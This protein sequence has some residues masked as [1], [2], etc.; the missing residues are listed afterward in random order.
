MNT[1]QLSTTN[2][3][4]TNKRRRLQKLATLG[5]RAAALLAL[6]TP[7]AA[8]GSY[9]Y[10]CNSLDD[11]IS[12]I[13]PDTGSTVQTLAAGALP[14]GIDSSSVGKEVLIAN[15]NDRTLTEIDN[16]TLTLQP[17]TSIGSQCDPTGLGCNFGEVLISPDGQRAYIS[18]TDLIYD[19]NI[20]G[21]TIMLAMDL[22]TRTL[23]RVT[24][25]I[26]HPHPTQEGTGQM[27]LTQDGSKLYTT[28]PKADKLF[29]IDTQTLQ[30]TGSIPVGDEPND[31]A[32]TP[33][34]TRMYVANTLSNDVSV[35]D[36]STD[37]VTAT[38][39]GLASGT[40]RSQAIDISPGGTRA[41]VVLRAQNAIA[42]ID[43]EPTSAT[44]HSVLG[45][46]PT[47]LTPWDIG[48]SNDGSKIFTCNI[49]DGTLT[50]LDATT[51][52][53]LATV[54]VGAQPLRLEVGGLSNQAPTADVSVEQLNAIG[55]DA[56]VRLDGSQSSDPDEETENLTFTWTVDGV[57]VCD[58][59]F[60]TCAQIEIS[61]PF[62][63]HTF[64][65]AVTDS[66]GEVDA[67]SR[68]VSIDPANL[69]VLAPQHAVVTWDGTPRRARLH[70]EIGLPFGV[71]YTEI[72]AEAMPSLDIA[73]TQV[74]ASNQVLFATQGP[75]DKKWTYADP[76]APSGIRRLQI[77]WEGS[78]YKY[79]S[80]GFPV[81]IQSHLIH[82]NET[83]LELDLNA[84]KISSSFT[85]DWNGQDSMTF[86]GQGNVT[87]S[88]VPYEVRKAGKRIE[89][90]LPFALTE[91]STIAFSGSLTRTIAVADDLRPSVGRFHLDVA[92][93]ASLHPA[94]V[95]TQPRSLFFAIGLGSQNYFGTSSLDASHLIADGDSW[96]LDRD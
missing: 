27:I 14:L 70:G 49:G 90:T 87:T 9:V 80:P 67:T 82:S 23:T 81:R 5:L 52:L 56:L 63:S 31:M 44:Y 88:S 84:K 26:S 83:Q 59:D 61:V 86:D 55:S 77:D 76:A 89:I 71:D 51:E 18:G 8:Q 4:T 66:E 64:G 17:S 30:V 33:D 35:I 36:L 29:V 93:D 37:T 72:T 48:L 6:A 15:L 32:I 65:L 91:L 28:V 40:T 58:G 39:S 1:I 20:S 68:T 24:G 73:G 19:P 62:G 53:I 79:S 10:V 95:N 46:M 57:L 16:D 85:I 94:G 69:S 22:A 7:L 21:I 78:R 38:I 47:G 54:T 92:F 12:V 50:I 42:T 60:A 13:D 2:L 41:Y 96:E 34:G 11:T 45:T 25:F 43:I 3:S 74:L 75:N